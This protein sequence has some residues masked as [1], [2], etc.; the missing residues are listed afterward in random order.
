MATWAIGDVHGCWATLE[1]LLVRLD[2]ATE[3]DSLWLVGDLVN[4]GPDSL[5]VLR[6]ARERQTAMGE[7]F[8]VT[9]GNHDLHLIGLAAGAIVPR[10]GDRLDEVLTAPDAPELIEWLAERPLLH[11]RG[12]SLLVHAGLFPSWTLE[13]AERRARA[14]ELALRDC[15]RRSK[16]LAWPAPDEPA[17]DLAALRRDLAVFSRLRTLTQNEE[18]CRHAGPPDGAP[19]GCRPWYDWPHARGPGTTVVFGHWAALGLLLRPEVIALDTGVAWGG[20]LTALRLEDRRVVSQPPLD[21]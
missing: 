6:W 18:P 4:R 1:A 5:A 20:A 11:R 19:L 13:Q 17:P 21:T 3:R 12:A 10:A 7:R 14:V 8:V 2:L 15:D 9:L 16:V